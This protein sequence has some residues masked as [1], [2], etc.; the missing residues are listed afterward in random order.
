MALSL[1]Q[2]F[3]PTAQTFGQIFVVGVWWENS[4]VYW[5]QHW[6]NFNLDLVIYFSQGNAVIKLDSGPGHHRETERK[7][8][9]E[10]ARESESLES[11]ECWFSFRLSTVA[12]QLVAVNFM[13]SSAGIHHFKDIELSVRNTQ[14]I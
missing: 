11:G 2:S 1:M 6:G 8:R 12:L 14:R 10:R 5:L 13:L 4:V 7:T 3:E 9:R